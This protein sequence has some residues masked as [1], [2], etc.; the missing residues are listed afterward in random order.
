MGHRGFTFIELMIVVAIIGVIAAIAIPNLLAARLSSN[1]TSVIGT[2]RALVAAQ[3]QFQARGVAD[4]D[5]DGLGEYGTFAELSGGVGV[6]GGAVIEPPVFGSSYRAINVHGEVV[7]RGY[8]YRIYLPDVNAK[9]L[10]EV[11]GGGPPVG[12]DP[13]LAESAWCCYAWPTN[14]ETTGMKTFFIGHGGDLTFCIHEGYS[15]PGACPP[16]GAAMRL[17]GAN[18]SITGAVATGVTGRDGHFWRSVSG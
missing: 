1:E 7:K 18:D 4:G 17:G 15:G 9:G 10:A 2:L 3:S 16:A 5:R 6:R 8:Q 12:I 13:D 11:P 14:F